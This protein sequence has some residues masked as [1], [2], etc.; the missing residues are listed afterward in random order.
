MHTHLVL[1]LLRATDRLSL[2]LSLSARHLAC[3]AAA[4]HLATSSTSVLVVAFSI[5]CVACVSQ[6][7]LLV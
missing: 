6:F 5:L 2:L 1:P 7:L 3:T 4:V